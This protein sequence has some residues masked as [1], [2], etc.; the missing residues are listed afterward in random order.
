[1]IRLYK[2]GSVTALSFLGLKTASKPEM[3]DAMYLHFS[4][5]TGD[6]GRLHGRTNDNPDDTARTSFL[7]N[8]RHV[9]RDPHNE[10]HPFP[11]GAQ[12]SRADYKTASNFYE[13]DLQRPEGS[14]PGPTHNQVPG[15]YLGYPQGQTAG[16][17]LIIGGD[18]STPKEKVNR[19][20]RANDE[21]TDSRVMEGGGGVPDS[22]TL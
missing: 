18:A 5:A 4:S 19:L 20:F 21:V 8:Q 10:A 6:D 15:D 9:L 17:R 22:P 14:G 3:G 1:M 13:S 2:L 12:R 16:Q 11:V 7:E